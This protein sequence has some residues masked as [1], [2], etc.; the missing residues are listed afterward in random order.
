MRTLPYVAPGLNNESICKDCDQRNKCKTMNLMITSCVHRRQSWMGWRNT[1]PD[2]GM[3]SP[4][5]IIIYNV[6][7]QE[8]K[9][10]ALSK[11]GDFSETGRLVY[12]KI[13]ISEDDTLKPVI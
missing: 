2:F 11:S 1:P 4:R 9:M 10:K 8:Y 7:L 12:N 13:T 5:N 3:G 6:G